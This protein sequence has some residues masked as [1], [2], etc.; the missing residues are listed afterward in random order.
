MTE[1]DEKQ[2]RVDCRRVVSCFMDGLPTPCFTQYMRIEHRPLTTL[3]IM[4]HRG[5]SH[6][7][8]A[9]VA[10]RIFVYPTNLDSPDVEREITNTVLHKAMLAIHRA[11]SGIAFPRGIKGI[12]TTGLVTESVIAEL[13]LLEATRGVF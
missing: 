2:F 7:L 11:V 5:E 8:Y 9:R 3:W 4:E 6:I 10:D 1:S 12:P 13:E